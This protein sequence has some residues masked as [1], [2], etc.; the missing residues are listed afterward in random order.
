MQKIKLYFSF[1]IP[2]KIMYIVPNPVDVSK[3]LLANPIIFKLR[4]I[5]QKKLGV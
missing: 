2:M 3:K 4:I 1:C 5:E